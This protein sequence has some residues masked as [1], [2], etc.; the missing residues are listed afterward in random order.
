[1]ET[2]EYTLL[3]KE[4]ERFKDY[5]DNLVSR[6]TDLYKS[7]LLDEKASEKLLLRVGEIPNI[8]GPNNEHKTD[9]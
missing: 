9:T 2:N 7:T 8:Q 4:A 5:M 3:I 1:M 6:S